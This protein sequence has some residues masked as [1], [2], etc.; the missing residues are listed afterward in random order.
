MGLINRLKGEE[1][2][3]IQQILHAF[4]GKGAFGEYLSDYAL[5]HG[6][7]PGKYSTFSNVYVPTRGRTSEI[8]IVMLHE[9][10]IFVFESKNYSGW[11][12]G[13]ENQKQWTQSVKGGFK[14]RFYNPI[15]QN[16]SH[17]NALRDHLQLSDEDFFSF[18][19]FSERCELKKI[20]SEGSDYVVIRRQ[21]LVK[22][23]RK[24]IES[25]DTRFDAE[26]MDAISEEL[27]T[28]EKTDEKAEAH[29]ETVKAIQDKKICPYCGAEL[30]K[31][32][33]KNG[34]FLGCKNYPKCHFTTSL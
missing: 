4:K 24:V 17:V 15:F 32:N 6:N 23:V 8:D 33:G 28:L 12:F 10:G 26:K 16:R 22:S 5:D 21:N 31:R 18:I 19:V 3:M 2:S 30:V 20:P 29:I 34:E 9:A 27:K 13:S 7:I 14:K 1:P 25:R 11:I